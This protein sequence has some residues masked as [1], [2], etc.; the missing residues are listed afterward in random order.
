M[1]LDP[2]LILY[3]KNKF[4]VEY[5]IKCGMT[6]EFSDLKFSLVARVKRP[7][8][9]FRGDEKEALVFKYLIQCLRIYK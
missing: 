1:K 5:K 3:T 7:H 9:A 8:R 2:Y 4:Q 6:A